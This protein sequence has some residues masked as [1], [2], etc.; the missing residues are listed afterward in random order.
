MGDKKMLTLVFVARN[1][2]TQNVSDLPEALREAGNPVWIV[3]SDGLTGVNIQKAA[4][5]F[6]CD[7]DIAAKATE[8]REFYLRAGREL[9]SRPDA[10]MLDNDKAEM[11]GLCKAFN[12]KE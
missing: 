6:L 1:P 3:V 9:E 7:L 5:D 4:T 11:W 2:V 10:I 8:P 12:R